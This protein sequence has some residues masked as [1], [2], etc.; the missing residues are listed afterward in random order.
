MDRFDLSSIVVQPCVGD[1]PAER[2]RWECAQ[3]GIPFA[4]SL[5]QM[6]TAARI[7][8]R[9]PRKAGS[10]VTERT[11]L[12]VVLAVLGVIASTTRPRRGQQ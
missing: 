6:E 2:A 10:G 8:A 7:L 1:T 5:E 12:A 4:P 3:Q 9:H 11:F